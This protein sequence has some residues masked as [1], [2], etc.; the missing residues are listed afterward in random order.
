MNAVTRLDPH[1][2]RGYPPCARRSNG[3]N[4]DYASTQRLLDQHQDQG[5][6]SCAFFDRHLRPIAQA[7]GQP[8]H[9]GSLAV[10]LPRVINEYGPREAGSG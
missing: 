1:P 6:L 7:S 10:L 2:L 9:L 4:G 8:I 3:G 5:R